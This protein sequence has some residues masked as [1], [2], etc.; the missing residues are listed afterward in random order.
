MRVLML[1][2]LTVLSTG[3]Y[4]DDRCETLGELAA[5]LMEVRQKND[6]PMSAMMDADGRADPL[7]QQMVREAW[8]VSAYSRPENQKRAIMDFR[9]KWERW[10]YNL[11]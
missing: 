4:A 7:W 9:S 11:K 8:G 5:T 3:V 10:C 1:I 2:A 6:V